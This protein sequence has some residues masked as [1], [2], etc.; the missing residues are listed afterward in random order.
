MAERE[1]DRD[2]ETKEEAVTGGQRWN[3]WA[4]REALAPLGLCEGLADTRVL[5][6]SLITADI[7]TQ[8]QEC[9]MSQHF[10]CCHESAPSRAASHWTSRFCS[11][12]KRRVEP[13]FRRCTV[14]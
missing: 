9:K 10:K 7:F 4:P 12:F 8:G 13:L 6:L 2:V 14:R 3:R 11:I 1:G 5:P